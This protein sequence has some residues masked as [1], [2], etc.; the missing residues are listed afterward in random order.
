MILGLA[1]AAVGVYWPST[2]VLFDAWTDLAGL[3]FTH[4]FLVA[5]AALALLFSN[6]QKIA[7]SPAAPWP[8]AC[9]F[10]L[11]GS[12]AWLICYRASIQDLHV[13][14]FPG[15]IWLAIAAAFGWR[16]ARLAILP[17]GLL[18][19]AVPSW[20]QANGPLGS[21]T[22]LV[23]SALM[24]V[25]GLQATTVGN[26]IRIP[27]GSFVIEEGCSGMH[28]LIVGLAVAALHGELRR[29]PVRT[30]IAQLGLMAVLALAANWLRVYL[31]ILAGY[32]TGM[33]HYLVSVT[34]YWF[35]WEIFAVALAVFFWLAGNLSRRL[36][37][38]ETNPPE[39]PGPSA[40]DATG[41]T[42][43][44]GVIVLLLAAPA[45]SYAVKALRGLPSPPRIEFSE[46]HSGWV[47][48]VSDRDTPWNPAFAG[49]GDQVRA[50][51]RDA[52]DNPV[53]VF[54]AVYAEQI[55]GAELVGSSDSLTGDR[56]LHIIDTQSVR[57]A[58]GSFN[59]AQVSDRTGGRSLIWSRYEVGQWVF[60]T[61]LAEQLWYGVTALG[62]W[63][64]SLFV[65][66]RAEC[67]PDCADA[68][69][70]LGD[71][72]RQAPWRIRTGGISGPGALAQD[73]AAKRTG[74]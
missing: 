66:F 46:G 14:I 4:G 72:V 24:R 23:T 70:R 17:V 74:G 1:A 3:S 20:G 32:L 10:L 65:A 58:G 16:V 49:A 48:P 71:L 54:V 61:P 45:T 31:I 63:P 60:V 13:A 36:V 69:R 68:R 33:R 34:H 55:Q 42:G 37:R 8:L 11:L 40:G 39:V 7:S 51:Y 57:S 6:R 41:T 73:A 19:L 50:L 18:Y 62:G 67:V 12:L 59:E 30:R 27:S 26:V 47:G 2:Q 53:E 56:R 5:A 38:S 29:E 22:V 64:P 21:L 35:G 25:T 43:Y 52:S 44:L 9:A 28:F 15:L